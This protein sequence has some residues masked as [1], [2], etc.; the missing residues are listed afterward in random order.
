MIN[1]KQFILRAGPALVIALMTPALGAQGRGRGNVSQSPKAAAP[2]DFT[3]Y[4][5]SIVVEDWRYRMLP[6]T[7]L[8]EKPVLGARIGIP[9]NP[10]ARK[11]ALAWDPAKEEAA[12][13]HCKAYGAANIMRI[14]GRIH[15]TWQDDQ[16]LKL[17]TDAGMQTRLFE[18]GTP[19]TA[20]GSWQGVSQAAWETVP[21][22]RGGA[23]S[24]GS[25]RVI[26][27]KLKPGYLQKNGIPY[28]ANAVVSEFYDRV[29]EPGAS[30]LVITTTVEDPAYLTEPYQ[31]SVHF[32]RQAD[33]SGW[34]PLPCSAR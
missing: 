11:V 15:V 8:E 30:Y 7:K 17:E 21:G 1:T 3:G 19:K 31:T 26:T 32:K 24:T 14:P 16:T 34:N 6:P 22:G 23:I 9:M 13:E 4:W 20:G 12:G 5:E 25:L 2:A 18:F 29:D 33:A 10:E 28:S 27:S